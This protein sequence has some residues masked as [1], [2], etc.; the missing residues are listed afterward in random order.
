MFGLLF[1]IDDTTISCH[2]LSNPT[3]YQ[4]IVDVEWNIIYEKLDK[5]VNSGAKFMLSHLVIRDLG[6]QY[7]AN[8]DV[9]CAGCVMEEDL[10]QVGREIGGSIQTIINNIVP[11]VMH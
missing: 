3:Q 10:Q 6:T 11:K 5:C 4:S 7:F 2:K 8:W 9:F 1:E